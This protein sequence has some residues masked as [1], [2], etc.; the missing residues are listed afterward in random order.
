MKDIVRLASDQW[1]RVRILSKEFVMRVIGCAALV[2]VVASVVSAQTAA[3]QPAPYTVV[4]KAAVGGTGGF[5]YLFAD[6]RGGKPYIPRCS[7]LPYK[8]Q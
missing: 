6:A 4:S 8:V 1:F 7:A 3:P 2:F 5:D